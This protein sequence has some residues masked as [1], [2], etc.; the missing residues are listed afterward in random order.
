MTR[1]LYSLRNLQFMLYEVFDILSLTKHERFSKH[2][3]QAF[4]LV[5]ETAEG[6]AKNFSGHSLKTVTGTRRSC[7]KGK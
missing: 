7:W 1:K 4:D 5:L 2:D 3:R 6:I